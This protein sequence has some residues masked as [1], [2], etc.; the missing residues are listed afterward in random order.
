MERTAI[1]TF[2]REQDRFW[3]LAAHPNLFAAGHDNGL[4]V[5]KLE[6]E[7]PAFSVFQDTLYYVRDKYVQ[8]YDFN[9]AADIGLLSVRKF[10][11]PYVPPRTLSFN[12]TERAVIL[13][14][15]SDSG[16]YELTNLP[17]QAQGEVKDSSVDGKKGNGQSAIFVARNSLIRQPRQV[18]FFVHNSWFSYPFRL[19]QLI[20]VRDLSNSVVKSIKPPVQ[21]NEIFYGG[22]A[23]LVL[24][25]T[26][27]VVLYDIQKTIA[28][29][30][31]PPVKYVV[32]SNDS[33]LVALM[34][35]HSEACLIFC[36]ELESDS[37]CHLQLSP[38]QIRPSLS[39]VSFMK[40]FESS[41]VPGTTR[42]FS[43]TQLWITLSTVSHKGKSHLLN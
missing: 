4:I 32:W 2:R 27:S 17:Q 7:R 30:N 28:E 20:E 33:S 11:S 16:M 14:I 15:S 43:F 26:T 23:C 37:C 42:E 8:S 35:K 22:T 41:L 19:I 12:P 34:S 10:G 29:I 5:F 6:R 21:T 3:V 13:T 9:T 36:L 24:S 39:T 25:S 31:S 1:Q 18:L 38:S 40:P